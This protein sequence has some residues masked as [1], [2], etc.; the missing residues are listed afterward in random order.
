MSQLIQFIRQAARLWCWFWI[1]CA[2]EEQRL[3]KFHLNSLRSTI[4]ALLFCIRFLFLLCFK[5]A[6]MFYT[7]FN[8]KQDKK[9][10]N[11]VMLN[12]HLFDANE[13][14]KTHTA[15]H[16]FFVSREVEKRQR[17]RG[18]ELE[19]WDWVWRSIC[20]DHKKRIIAQDTHHDKWRKNS[21]SSFS[22]SWCAYAER[23]SSQARVSSWII[24]SFH[25]FCIVFLLLFSVV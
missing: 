7:G 22:H 20:S 19:R 3:H 15:C 24:I 10:S 25:H 14:E 16:F 6:K 11:A 21:S 23:Q 13:G 8:A 17:E 1:G 9:Q 12:V 5:S 2:Q 18:R 4:Y